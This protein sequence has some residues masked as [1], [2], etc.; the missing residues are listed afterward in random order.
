MKTLILQVYEDECIQISLDT[1]EESFRAFE[2]F[3]M[4]ELFVSS[5]K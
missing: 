2:Q 1:H 5:S 3:R 4:F